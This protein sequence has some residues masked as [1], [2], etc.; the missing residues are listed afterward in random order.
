M[1]LTGKTNKQTTIRVEKI[2]SYSFLSSATFPVMSRNILTCLPNW[3]YYSDYQN[4]SYWVFGRTPA[5]GHSCFFIYLINIHYEICIMLI[6]CWSLTIYQWLKV[7]IIKPGFFTLISENII[8]LKIRTKGILRKRHYMIKWILEM[9]HIL[10]NSPCP[11][12]S[13]KLAVL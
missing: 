6:I 13:K 11:L 5:L 10:R 9:F 2:F 3:N 8:S 12:L 4:H 1:P 7:I